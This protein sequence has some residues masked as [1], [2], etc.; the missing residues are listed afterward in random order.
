MGAKFSLL[1]WKFTEK[2]GEKARV[3][4]VV[5]DYSWRYQDELMFSLV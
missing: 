2:Q 1:E 5:M 4:Y 3:I